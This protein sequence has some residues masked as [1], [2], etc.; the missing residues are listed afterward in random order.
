MEKNKNKEVLKLKDEVQYLSGKMKKLRLRTR[1]EEKKYQES[2][3]SI[4]SVQER[5][6]NM[7]EIIRFKQA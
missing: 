3:E 2:H 4:V 7:N 5:C 6:R 1:E